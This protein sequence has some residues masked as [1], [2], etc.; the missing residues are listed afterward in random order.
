MYGPSGTSE[1][2]FVDDEAA[3]KEAEEREYD[4]RAEA[5]IASGNAPDT[6][7]ATAA[8]TPP[9]PR[10]PSDEFTTYEL[11]VTPFVRV[12]LQQH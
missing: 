7:F 6:L 10:P 8:P 12:D 1:F 4:A 5:E 3:A 11:D 9:V 2:E